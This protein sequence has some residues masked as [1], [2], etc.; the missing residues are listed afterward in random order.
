MDV[1]GMGDFAVSNFN[2]KTSFTFRIPSV[3]E[4]DFLKERQEQS[5]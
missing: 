3:A 2:G 4:A 5:K 1:I